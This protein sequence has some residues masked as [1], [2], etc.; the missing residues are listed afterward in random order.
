MGRRQ[1]SLGTPVPGTPTVAPGPK[2]RSDLASRRSQGESAERR[3][4]Q[5]PAAPLDAWRLIGRGRLRFPALPRQLPD[6][7]SPCCM[8]KNHHYL[9]SWR[10]AVGLPLAI[11]EERG[12]A[13]V[14]HLFLHSA[15]FF[16]FLLATLMA[17]VKMFSAADKGEAR[18]EGPGSPPPKR[19]RGRPVS[20]P[21][22]QLWP[23][24]GA[25]GPLQIGRAHV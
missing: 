6:L 1:A 4:P 23:L 13:P 19:G 18:K 8:Q 16:F 20:T 17:L 22:L 9:R 24:V 2:A 14:T 11:N 12:R 5:Q 7:T 21:R 15:R 3:G 25:G 10:P